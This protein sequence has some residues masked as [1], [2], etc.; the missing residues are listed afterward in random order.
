MKKYK[1]F[2]SYAIKDKKGNVITID[3]GTVE[4][5]E[6]I[7][8]YEYANKIEEA[9]KKELTGGKDIPIKVTIIWY[10]LIGKEMKKE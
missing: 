6:E 8:S 3:N 7:R 4:T 1:Y 9:L 10:S 2:V 5:F